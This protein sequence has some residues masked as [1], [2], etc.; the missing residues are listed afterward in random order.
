MNKEFVKFDKVDK[1][2]D[3]KVLVV[4]D[5]QLDIEEGEF[6][7][8]LG[9]SGSGK[10][11][12]LMML[13]GFETPTNG[14]IF[15]DTKPISKIPPYEREIGMVFQNYALFPHMTV[16]ENLSFPLE[17]R[18]MSKADAKEK[19]FLDFKEITEESQQS[20]R[21]DRVSMQ[22]A[23]PLGRVILAF[24]NT[25][26]QYTRLTKKAA[27]DLINRRGDWKTNLSKLMYYGAVQNIIFTALQSA[28]FAMLFSDSD[29]DKEKE[30]Y[31]RIGNGI[32]D[33]LLRGSGVAGAAVATAKNM[34]VKAIEQYKSGRPNYE[35]VAMELTTLS[36]PINSK[37]RK[38]QSA[39]RAFTYKQNLEKMRE[40]GPLSIDNPAYMAAAQTLSAVANVPL[41]RALRKLENLGDS[42][43]GNSKRLT[44]LALG[45]VYLAINYLSL[46]S[47]FLRRTTTIM[48]NWRNVH[49]SCYF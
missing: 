10:T 47:S 13:A 39:G 20:S 19:A 22:Q 28:M 43:T 9:P 41:D 4:K 45:P 17:V 37:L 49:N 2:Y 40:E 16:S 42:K 33:T 35:K 18:K 34:V 6:V 5:L 24:A 26:M 38:L 23:S 8:M 3:G 32:A 36:P 27:L 1:S 46:Y 12:C 29:D 14:E 11:T 30:R 44:I 21:P 48:R 25:P 15:L 31:G 7:T